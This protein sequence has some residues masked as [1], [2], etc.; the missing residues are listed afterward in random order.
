MKQSIFA[1]AAVSAL[2][3]SAAMAGIPVIPAA[4]S[5]TDTK[6]YAGLN[7]TVD[8]G[9]TPALV[10]GVFHT[11]VKSNGDTTG[12]NLAFHV[13]LAGGVKPGKL[14]LSYL[15]GQDNL[16]GEVGGGYDFIKAAPL[17]FLGVNSPHLAVGIDG[18]MNPG[19]VPYATVHT[20]DEFDLPAAAPAPV[21]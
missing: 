4:T 15:N 17:V 7:W 13:N 9:L 8:G 1:V 10:L 2:A 6:A 11:K 5:N 18:Y 16:Q 14:K 21:F 12:G 19:L 3:C 20:Q